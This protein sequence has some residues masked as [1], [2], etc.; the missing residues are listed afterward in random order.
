MESSQKKKIR[1]N[2]GANNQI[3]SQGGPAFRVRKMKNIEADNFMGGVPSAID[4]M[5]E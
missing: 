2:Y 3:T 4:P 1:V 5:K